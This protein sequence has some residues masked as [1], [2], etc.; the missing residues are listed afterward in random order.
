MLCGL[1]ER[2]WE[3]ELKTSWLSERGGVTQ[4]VSGESNEVASIMAV[5]YRGSTKALLPSV[6]QISWSSDRYLGK[7]NFKISKLLTIM[8]KQTPMWHVKDWNHGTK[9]SCVYRWRLWHYFISFKYV[10]KCDYQRRGRKKL[11]SSTSHVGLLYLRKLVAYVRKCHQMLSK[12][13]K[14]NT[15]RW[16]THQR[17]AVR[18]TG[19]SP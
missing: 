9:P 14:T 8:S 17:V 11:C 1:R 19:H 5:V 10:V 2:R 3:S 13:S 6:L 7:R 12:A 4:V 16:L 15:M 18:Q